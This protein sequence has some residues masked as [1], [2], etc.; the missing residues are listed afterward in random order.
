MI[1]VSKMNSL[2][3][4]SP[5]DVTEGKIVMVVIEVHSWKS[6]SPIQVM[7]SEITTLVRD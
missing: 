6:S 7:D 3:I 5:I 4:R 2:N 1:V